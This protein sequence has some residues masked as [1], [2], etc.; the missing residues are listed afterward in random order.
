MEAAVG[1]LN[2]I[3]VVV[4]LGD[5]LQIAQ[6]GVFTYYEFLQPRNDRLTDEAWRINAAK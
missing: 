5:K 3:Y 6:G 2:R 1:Y 4:P